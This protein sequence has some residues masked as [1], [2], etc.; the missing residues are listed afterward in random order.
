MSSNFLRIAKSV[1]SFIII[2][3]VLLYTSGRVNFVAAFSITC[4]FCFVWIKFF[5]LLQNKE[6]I[7]LLFL[8]LFSVQLAHVVLKRTTFPFSNIGMYSLV[9]KEKKEVP[10]TR[11]LYDEREEVVSTNSG[12][13]VGKMD[14]NESKIVTRLLK[15]NDKKIDSLILL[16][17]PG[18]AIK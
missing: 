13:I 14:D 8:C 11:N 18:C 17:Y 16:Y 9:Q 5:F 15:K 3:H 4:I 2:A 7:S 12:L 10:D 6:T 1:I